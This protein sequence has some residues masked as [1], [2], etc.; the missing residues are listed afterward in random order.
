MRRIKMKEEKINEGVFEVLAAVLLKTEVYCD[1]TPF[2]VVNTGHV[3]EDR[4]ATILRVK[5]DSHEHS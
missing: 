1:V 2:W 5:P 3:S 4:R